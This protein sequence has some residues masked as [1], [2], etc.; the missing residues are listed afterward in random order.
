MLF[1]SGGSA[2]NYSFTTT[3]TA[4]ATVTQAP[5]VVAA[6]AKSVSYGEAAPTFTFTVAGFKNS[7]TTS[8]AAGY[9]APTCSAPSYTRTSAV[10]SSI[11]ISCSGAVATNYSFSYTSAALT[12]TTRPTLTITA[13]SPS[14]ITYGAS[15][16]ANGYS[17]SGLAAND[18][19]SGLTYT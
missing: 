12:I 3:A 4:T 8:T 2:T 16:P 10:G 11:T 13:N 15:T 17:T 7:Q 6:E 9:V 5:L 1:R 14:A 19:I 18:V